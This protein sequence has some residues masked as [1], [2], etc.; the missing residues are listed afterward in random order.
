MRASLGPFVGEAV[1]IAASDA[2]EQ[3]VGLHLAQV[4]AKLFESV[5]AGGEAEGG[6][7][8]L[9]DIGGPPSVELCAAVL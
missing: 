4:I 2:F 1:E 9:R 8:S 7:D 6:E 5:G 3:A